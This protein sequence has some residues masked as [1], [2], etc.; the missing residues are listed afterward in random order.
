MNKKFMFSIALLMS[1]V[2]GSGFTVANQTT[3]A[4]VITYPYT[5]SLYDNAYSSSDDKYSSNYDKSEYD[6]DYYP[7]LTYQNNIV[8]L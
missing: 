3:M 8:F 4:A 1:I 5:N 2:L 7:L 6:Y